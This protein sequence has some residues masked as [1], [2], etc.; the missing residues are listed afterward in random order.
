[1]SPLG[2]KERADRLR[3]V[4]LESVL[5]LA[6]A[7]RDQYDRFKWHTLQG[8]LSITGAKFMNWTRGVGGGGA[9]DLAMHLNHACF[10]EALQWLERGVPALLTL[11]SSPPP[12]P[13]PDFK[14]PS[15]QPGY[16]ERVKRYLA[17]QRAIP[18]ALIQTL[19][20]SGTLYADHRANAVFVLLGKANNPVGAEMRGTGPYPWRGMAPGSQKD[21]G[22][23][24]TPLDALAGPAASPEKIVLCES[25]ID[26][27]SCFALH[28]NHR[29][30]STVGARPNPQW[31]PALLQ[32][33]CPV[34]CGFD[35]DCTG[36]TMAQ[37]MIALHPTIQRSRPPSHDWN[38]LL[39][40]VR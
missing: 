36:E 9:I 6:G 7:Q 21:L 3:A 31:L 33:G 26:A 14:L 35:A 28:P 15:P 37:A 5:R 34:C 39:R 23:F 38:D 4:P 22:F 10:N 24:S 32:S 8:T 13:K 40:S 20:Q 19:I 2:H 16:L 18:A 25:A 30:I 17:L 29:C 11:P 12:P 1:V 27:L